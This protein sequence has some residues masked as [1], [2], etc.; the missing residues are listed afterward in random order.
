VEAMITQKKVHL[1][2]VEKSS[3]KHVRVETL[4]AE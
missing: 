2:T 1:R 3:L 4:C